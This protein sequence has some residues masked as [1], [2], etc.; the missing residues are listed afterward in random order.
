[1]N[2]DFFEKRENEDFRAY[3]H[4][5]AGCK[6]EYDLTWDDIADVTN[7]VWCCNFSGDKYR[8]QEQRLQARIDS[9]NSAFEDNRWGDC[10]DSIQFKLEKVKESDEKAQINALYRRISREETLKEIAREAVETLKHLKLDVHTPGCNNSSSESAILVISDWHYGIN[11]DSYF[12]QYSPEIARKRISKLTTRVAEELWERDIN[13]LYVVNLGDLICGNIH[14]KLRLNSRIDAITQIMQ[15]SELV[16]QMLSKLSEYANI[17]YCDTLDN[18]S[19]VEPNI[20]DSLE[21]ESLARLTK[22][23]LK[24]RLPGIDYIENTYGDDIIDFELKGHKIIGVHGHKDKPTKIIDNLSMLTHNHYDLV[25]TAHLH[26][27]SAEEK[28]DTLC[29]SNS[30]L[31]GTDQFAQDLRM[32]SKPSQNLII[33]SNDNV[34]KEIVRILL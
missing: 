5:I 32:D 23:Y 16:A 19:R 20:K 8:K 17:H 10:G 2:S 34:A 18:H 12:N 1:M 30:S 21:L 7:K 33:V 4:R 24:E 14:L 26:H 11:I 25:L 29:I 6:E 3:C 22:W 9:S 28:N 13:D 15:V 31:M 27:F